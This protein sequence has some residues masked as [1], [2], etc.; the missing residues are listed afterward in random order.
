MKQPLTPEQ[1]AQHRAAVTAALLERFKQR[2]AA[3][4]KRKRAKKGKA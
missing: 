2:R 4:A 1:L 3:E